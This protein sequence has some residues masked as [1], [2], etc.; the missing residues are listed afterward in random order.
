ML[1]RI[2]YFIVRI[3][4]IPYY[5]HKF[6]HFGCNSLITNALMIRGGGGCISD[7]MLQFSINRGLRLIH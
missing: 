6:K 1:R 4:K 3:I 5:K 7:P 2:I